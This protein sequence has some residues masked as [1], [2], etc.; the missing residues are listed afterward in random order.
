MSIA[1]RYDVLLLDLKRVNK[2][3]GSTVYPGQVLFVPHRPSRFVPPGAAPPRPRWDC[4]RLCSQAPQP[5]SRKDGVESD[6][7]DDVG[8]SPV[9][10]VRSDPGRRLTTGTAIREH[11]GVGRCAR[12]WRRWELSL[13]V[14]V[15]CTHA[16]NARARVRANT[17]LRAHV[18]GAC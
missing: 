13:E 8:Y 18:G 1:M 16:R 9:L 11:H 3:Y 4:C 7:V 2:I 17:D 15:Y 10:Q 6:T 5:T 14:G 12:S